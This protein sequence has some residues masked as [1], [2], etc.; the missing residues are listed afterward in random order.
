LAA[1]KI[2][3]KR[4]RLT[5]NGRAS[6]LIS[7]VKRRIGIREFDLTTAWA[8]DILKIGVCQVTK[9]P[10][11][12][13]GIRSPFIP[14]I[15]RI[16]STK[17]YTTD[18]SQIVIFAYNLAKDH[19][20]HDDV[21]MMAKALVQNN[22]LPVQQLDQKLSY[23]RASR[24]RQDARKKH[25]R[26]SNQFTITTNQIG[27]AIQSGKCAITG[28]PF[29]LS[30]PFSPLTPSLDQI[31]PGRGYTKTNTQIVSL[32]YNLAKGNWSHDDVIRMAK[33]LMKVE[34]DTQ[35]IDSF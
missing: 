13:S 11:D 5:I 16:D 6:K 4:S 7:D 8:I 23:R 30:K 25:R 20:S 34:N 14:S 29:D 3:R 12:F 15:D 9:I 19:W 10:F 1:K 21:M 33:S 22:N 31:I 26:K 2:E 32:I 35:N 27:Q 24:L 17:G 28:L 18:N